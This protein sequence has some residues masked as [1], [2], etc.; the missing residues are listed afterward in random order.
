VFT[1]LVHG[2]SMAPTL[3]HGDALL[4]RRGGR[5]VKRAVREQPDGWWV[6]SDNSLTT[7]D[8][9]AYGPAAVV[10]RVVCRWWPRP[11]LLSRRHRRRNP[12]GD[13]HV[14]ERG[15]Q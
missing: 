3:R 15:D 11:A 13:G 12:P 9:R 7:D 4:V 10:G 6:E 5:R 1:A 2:P 14:P 8:S